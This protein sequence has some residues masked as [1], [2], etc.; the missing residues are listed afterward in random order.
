MSFQ[1]QLKIARSSIGYTQQQISDIMG[2]SK[3]TYCGYETGKRQPD[4]QKIKQLAKILNTSGD[5]LLETGFNEASTLLEKDTPTLDSSVSIDNNRFLIT[6][7]DFSL[8]KLEKN[9]ILAYRDA[10]EIGQAMVLRSLN[11]ED[12]AK[13]NNKKMA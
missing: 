5:V 12:D 2:I 3:S 4:V 8:S 11:I 6:D 10:D 1:D 13:S 7:E 9:I